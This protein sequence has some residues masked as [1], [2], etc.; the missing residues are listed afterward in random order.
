MKLFNFLVALLIFGWVSVASAVNLECICTGNDCTAL[1]VTVVQGVTSCTTACEG[2]GGDCV[3]EDECVGQTCDLPCGTWLGNTPTPT[4]TFLNTSTQ[5]PTR[6]RTQTLTPTTSP[7][8]TKTPTPTLTRTPIPTD[9]PDK[10]W[11]PTRTPT[12]TRTQTPTRTPT[13]TAVNTGTPTRTPTAANTA[14]ITPTVTPT[15]TTGFYPRVDRSQTD[16][17]TLLNQAC[18][19]PPCEGHHVPGSKGYMTATCEPYA[20]TA[21]VQIYCY[22]HTGQWQGTPIPVQTPFACPGFTGFDANFDE[23]WETIT[24]AAPNPTPTGTPAAA[25]PARVGGWIDREAPP[26]AVWW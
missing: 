25:V 14:T 13:K 2:Q 22:G 19:T 5:T 18:P 17:A 3:Q 6:T 26:G 21:T 8:I 15:G 10:T 11:T 16:N 1:C 9:T 12:S 23:C 7:T 4:N 24:A 20:G